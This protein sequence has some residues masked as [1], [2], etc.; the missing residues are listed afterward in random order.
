MA[1]VKLHDQSYICQ[2]FLSKAPVDDGK[3]A[4]NIDWFNPNDYLGRKG[5]R[6]YSTPI[7]Q[8]LSAGSCLDRN[9]S[10][11]KANKSGVFIGTS[12]VDLD[13]RRAITENFRTQN[14]TLVGA[15]SAPNCSVNIAASVLAEKFGF[16][17]QCFTFTGGED[18][19][20]FA[21]WKAI[22]SIENGKL[23]RCIVGQVEHT[24]DE[25]AKSGAILWDLD[26][27]S[28]E[29]NLLIRTASVCR[30]NH[31]SVQSLNICKAD[32]IIYFIGRDSDCTNLV[33]QNLMQ[34]GINYERI[35]NSTIASTITNDMQL[36]A[37]L[38]LLARDRVYGHILIVSDKGHIFH[39]NLSTKR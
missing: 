31:F 20:L 23:S 29:D 11:E 38:S 16:T 18:S 3:P 28:K 4:N 33:T 21:L 8:I 25:P 37:N 15:A 5:H 1:S 27:S 17:G 30:S 24:K 36:F 2:N 34:N 13:A 6:Y 7:K 14:D 12:T 10:S 35:W 32:E 9:T 22:N 19:S 26:N 39:L